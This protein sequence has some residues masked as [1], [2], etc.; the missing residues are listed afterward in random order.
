MVSLKINPSQRGEKRV[1][2]QNVID[3][4]DIRFDIVRPNQ[5]DENVALRMAVLFGAGDTDDAG[6]PLC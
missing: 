5:Q 6:A 3:I 1:I 2:G 4:T